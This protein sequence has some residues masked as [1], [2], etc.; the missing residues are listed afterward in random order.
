MKSAQSVNY[1]L[2]FYSLALGVFSTNI[3]RKVSNNMLSIRLNNIT[4][5]QIKNETDYRDTN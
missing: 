3:Y 4:W 2:K 1:L 5:A